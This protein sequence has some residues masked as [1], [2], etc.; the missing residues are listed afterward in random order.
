[1][2][3]PMLRHARETSK[4][5]ARLPHRKS[6]PLRKL[7]RQESGASGGAVFMRSFGVSFVYEIRRYMSR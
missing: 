6:I 1:M 4:I 5:V 2:P 3:A 7:E